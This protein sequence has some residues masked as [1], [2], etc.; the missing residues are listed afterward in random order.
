M[1]ICD[2]SAYGSKWHKDG[3]GIMVQNRFHVTIT[4]ILDCI[5]PKS[6][7]TAL[8]N[9]PSNQHLSTRILMA[10][11]QLQFS[12]IYF[13]KKNTTLTGKVESK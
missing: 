3:S 10:N 4:I 2:L 8:K 9:S 7:P 5:I 11:L 13:G 12:L 6:F 1:N